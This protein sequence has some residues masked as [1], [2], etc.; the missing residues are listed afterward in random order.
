MATNLEGALDER[1]EQ[2]ELVGVTRPN[3]RAAVDAQG[4]GLGGELRL[5]GG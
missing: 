3:G 5:R 4:V 1:G 2:G